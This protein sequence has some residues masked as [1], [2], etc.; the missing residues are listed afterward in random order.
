MAI[1]INTPSSRRIATLVHLNNLIALALV[2]TLWSSAAAAADASL[3]RA[4]ITTNH[5][6]LETGGSATFT[7]GDPITLQLRV[8]SSVF[9]TAQGKLTVFKPN[10]FISS[11]SLGW[12]FTNVTYLLNTHVG[13]PVGVHTV[14]FKAAA[15]GYISSNTC[16]FNVIASGPTPTPQQTRTPTL[17]RTPTNTRTQTPTHVPGTSPLEPHI[18]TNR[19]CDETGDS[20]V[21]YAGEP[22]TISFGI[23]SDT[24]ATANATLFDMLPNGFVNAFSFG[25]ILT[26]KTYTFPATVAPPYGT[27]VLRLRAS[28]FGVVSANA[29]CSFTVAPAPTRTR[30]STR[31]RTPTRT[32]TRTKTETPTRTATA[33]ATVP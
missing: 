27:E 16:S 19:G 8:S 24:R 33:T 30:T 21:F 14:R 18:T 2:A 1:T 7:I 25:T 32:P 26:N 29:F 28:A 13:A 23:D 4:Q 5:G 17:S 20:P 31:T 11:F 6:C 12:L 22:I 15:G 9:D 10:G 3:L